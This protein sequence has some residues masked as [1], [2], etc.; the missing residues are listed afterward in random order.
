M[1]GRR[2]TWIDR[3]CREAPICP[4]RA[5]HQYEDFGPARESGYDAEETC[6]HCGV[7][8]CSNT[9][10]THKTRRFG[11]TIVGYLRRAKGENA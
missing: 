3:Y 7:V 8:R 2:E 11:W 9:S 5:R 4:D 6:K 10:K 1:T